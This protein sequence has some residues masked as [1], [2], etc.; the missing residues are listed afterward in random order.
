MNIK[1]LKVSL[2]LTSLLVMAAGPVL[3]QEYPASNGGMCSIATLRGSFGYTSTGTL[4]LSAVP[5]P[6]AGPFAEVGIQ[7][8][9]GRGNTQA[10]ATIDSNGNINQQVGISGTYVVNSDCTGSMTL[11][12]PALGATVHADFVIDHNRAEIRAVSTDSGIIESRI[13]R[14]QSWG[15]R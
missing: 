3:A 1:L 5:A 13:Y 4:L 12:V 14:K 9:D 11:S 10:T 15:G 7:S 8:F 6:Y 2:A